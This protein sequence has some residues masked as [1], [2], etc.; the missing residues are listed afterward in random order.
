MTRDKISKRAREL[1]REFERRADA[2]EFERH[3]E[4]APANATT[5]WA[6]AGEANRINN[7]ACNPRQALRALKARLARLEKL[8][9]ISNDVLLVIV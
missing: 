1:E 3:A 4:T 8:E 7:D 6:L 9:V 5:L 2:F